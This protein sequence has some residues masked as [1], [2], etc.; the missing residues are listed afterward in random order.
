MK[1]LLRMKNYGSL[2]ALLPR[3]PKIAWLCWR[4]CWDHRVPRSLKGM[5][6]ASLVY[7]VSPVDLVPG[8]LIPV[9]GQLDDV[10]LLVLTAYFFIRWSPSEVVA[11][12]MTSMDA[13]H[14]DKFRSWLS[15]SAR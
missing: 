2:L 15:H 1:G 11:E 10:T 7:A 12:H 13:R 6:L 3:L 4:L 14:F 8:F 5:M 9:L